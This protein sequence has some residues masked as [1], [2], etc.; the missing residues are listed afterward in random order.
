MP[1]YALVVEYD[2][3]G[4]PLKSWHDSTGLTID[5]ASTAV[6]HDG[7]LYLGSFHKDYIGIAEY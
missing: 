4:N 3:N 2:L 5:S 1:N 6:L 7:K